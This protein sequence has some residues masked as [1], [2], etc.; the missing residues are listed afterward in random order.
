MA[1]RIKS[2]LAATVVGLVCPNAVKAEETAPGI[3]EKEDQDKEIETIVVTATRTERDLFTTPLSATVL[4]NTEFEVY[5]PQNFGDIFESIPGATIQGGSRRIAQE[6][7]IRGFVDQQLVLR[8][9]GARQNFDLAHR[10]R[11]F[12]DNDIVKRIEVL[13]GG[14]SSLF[15]SGAIGGV[16]S[17]ETMGARDLLQA[18]ETF[19]ARIKTGYQTNGEEP[20]LSGGVFGAAS[21]VDGLLNFVYRDIRQDLE[22]GNGDPILDTTE[23]VMNGLAKVGFEPTNDQRIELIADIYDSDGEGPTDAQDASTAATNVQRDVREYNIRTNYAF[24]PAD[25]PWIDVKAVA[26]YT[27]IDVT[28]DRFI[29]GRF[30]ETDFQSYGIDL[31]NTS[32]FDLGAQTNIA[33]TYGFEYFKDE[34]SGIRGGLG[35]EFPNA[36]RVFTAGFAQAELELFDRISIIPGVR[37]DRFQLEAEGRDDR[38]ESE[39]SPRIAAG[40]E[41]APWLYLWAAYSEAFRAPSL[42]ELYNSGIHFQVDGGLGSGTFVTNEFVVSPDLDP[43]RAKT[44]E[45]GFRVRGTGLVLDNDKVAISGTFYQADIDDFIDSVVTFVDFSIPPVFVPPFGPLVFTGTTQSTNVDAE[46]KGFEGEL[47]YQS[48]YFDAKLVG[49]LA[50]GKN[51]TTDEG[52]GSIPQ[53]A[54]TLQL[55]WKL[56]DR[57]VRIGGRVTKASAQNDVP[58]GTVTTDGYETVDVFASWAPPSGH[59]EGAVFTIGGDNVFDEVY[60]VHPQAILQPGKSFRASVSFRFG[61]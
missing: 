14:A 49:S 36:D 47:E 6:P 43:E 17:L 23:R 21:K 22:D 3:V 25:R 28:E 12:A 7:S 20:V 54:A 38:T 15:G 46:I 59:L 42:T 50:D 33:L 32:R 34:Q 44:F 8:L 29:D 41:P 35:R 52:L 53:N 9:D 51:S 30:D 31:S 1:L 11:F 2:I 56:P 10:G 24:S 27:D 26:Y 58:V 45:A 61:G 40:V 55:T 60:A 5:Q 19:G 48:T 37:F 4:S 57:G 18:D 39:F 16:I 13:R